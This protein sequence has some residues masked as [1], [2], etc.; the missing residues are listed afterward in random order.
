MTTP[1]HT[2]GPWHLSKEFDGNVYSQSA[3]NRIVANVKDKS[4]AQLIALAPD[5]YDELN[6]TIGILSILL[7]LNGRDAFAAKTITSRIKSIQAV[8][9]KS[10]GQ[11]C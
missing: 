8:I 1:Q 7:E 9:E 11:S 2:P 10:R 4:N 3:I 6:K 5:M